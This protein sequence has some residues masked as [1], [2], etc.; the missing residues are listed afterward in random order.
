MLTKKYILPFFLTISLQFIVISFCTAQ[1][2]DPEKVNKKAGDIYGQAI[3]EGV[4]G[5]YDAAIRYLN[6]SIKLDPKLVDAYISK[7]AIYGT[8]KKYDSSITGYEQA[9][10][11]DSVYSKDYLL[12]YSISLAG[13]GKFQ[14]ALD[15]VNKF[16]TDEKLNK[17][18]IAAGNFRKTTYEFALNYDKT[19]PVKNYVFAPQ[20]LGDSINSSALE[21]YPS[22]TIDGSKMVFTR[23]INSDEDFYESN[24]ADGKWSK[25]KPL[26]GKVNTN[27][28][29]GAQCISQDG[30]WI[31]FAGC[32]Y[33]E[34]QGECDLYIS[35]KTKNGWSEAENLGPMVNT[36]FWESSP[37]LSP[38]KRDLYFSSAVAGGF[39]GRDIWVTHRSLTGKW[40]R[41]ENLGA[42]VNTSGDESCPFMHADNETLYFNSNGRPGYGS[43][44]LF[45]TKKV[46]DTSWLEAENLG[47]PIN[48]IDDEGS[49][50]VAADAKTA[51]YASDRADGKGG[52]DLY[53]FQM[54]EDI[55]PLKTLW[56]SGKVFDKKTMAGLPSSVELINLKT[57]NTISKIQTDEEGNYLATLPVGKDYAFNVNRRGYLF[58]SDNFALDANTADSVFHKDIPLQP[59]EAGAFI[60]LKNIFFDTKK[61]DLKPESIAELDK[62]VLLLND[63]PKLRIEIDGH[64]DNVGLAKDNLTLS[65]NRAKA[66][67]DYLSGKG[68]A[69][70]RLSFKGFGATKPMADNT[71]DTGKSQNRRTELSVISN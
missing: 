40:S 47:Y 6:E 71:T 46:S 7:A 63:N 30:Q 31:I 17:K 56:V 19:H 64:T 35:Y 20:N 59:L 58:Y 70:A 44:D 55:R 22:L 51:Y 43:T 66:V 48:T 45:F 69:P 37:S 67:V 28:N 1:W 10:A 21:Y 52:L 61:F 57:R 15:A 38:D 18:S 25:A 4:A 53:T 42:A 39:G 34:G 68:I 41:P 65:N 8:L 32:N 60:V 14:L 62:V 2:Y 29:E 5:N 9:F 54:R 12:P 23:R 11:L 36:D 27:F 16:L 49:L 26:A 24:F 3:N 33:P 50:I 13:T